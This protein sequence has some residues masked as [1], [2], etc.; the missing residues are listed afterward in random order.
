MSIH[1]FFLKKKFIKKKMMSKRRTTVIT[2]EIKDK[3]N[4]P[5]DFLCLDSFTW[6]L[7]ISRHNS[8]VHQFN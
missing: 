7:V 4:G 8:M 3:G 5:Q 6:E 1:K 2:A